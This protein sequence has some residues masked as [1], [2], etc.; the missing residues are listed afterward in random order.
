MSVTILSKEKCRLSP[1]QIE[2]MGW[3]DVTIDQLPAK[4][5]HAAIR[6]IAAQKLFDEMNYEQAPEEIR[7]AF[8]Q[9]CDFLFVCTLYE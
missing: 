9:V 4:R 1:K 2:S 6:A 3:E 7:K 8:F 5:K